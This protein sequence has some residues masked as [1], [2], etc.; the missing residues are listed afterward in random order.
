MP[1]DRGPIIP[2]LKIGSLEVKLP[3]IQGGMG[4]GISRSG[5]ASAVAAAGGIGVIA[6]VGLGALAGGPTQ[7]LMSANS[8]AL[9][10]E[11][12]RAKEISRG[13]IGVNV[14]SVVSDSAKLIETAVESG[15][16]V[17]FLGAGVPRLP[18][19]V[20][21]ALNSGLSTHL[22]VIVSSLRAMRLI[23][24]LWSKHY[25]SVPD[26]VVVEGPMAG[27]HLGFRKEHLNDPGHSIEAIL[28]DIVAETARMEVEHCKSIPVIAAGGIFTGS[29]ACRMLSLGA[30]G[31][32]MG[33][34]FA[35]TVESDAADEF[36]Q[37]YVRS[38]KEDIVIID[39]PVGMPGRA[40]GNRFTEDVARGRKKPFAC[41]YKCLRTCDPETAPYCIAGA[42]LRAVQGDLENGF[43]FAGANAWRVDSIITVEELITS[44]VDEFELCA[45]STRC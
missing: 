3:I 36:K 29:D 12:R 43:A 24:R 30:H 34:R 27:G 41:P 13:A 32:Q 37:A 14:M 6:S 4:V 16:D 1:R 8:E 25:A 31:I 45:A 2:S 11:I 20:A 18:R 35:A 19:S 44:L 5:L 26:A 23:F 42:L 22:A 9:G 39:S 7:D 17:L 28:P 40:I 21:R 38:S 10:R 15:A 33:T